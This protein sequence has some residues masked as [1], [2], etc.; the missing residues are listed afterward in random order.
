MNAMLS[1]VRKL[2]ASTLTRKMM[3]AIV[4]ALAEHLRERVRHGRERVPGRPEVRDALEDSW[5]SGLREA[6]W[7]P[8]PAVNV[9]AAAVA[10][11][12]ALRPG[13]VILSGGNDA[14][15]TGPDAV[16]ER[17]ETESVLLSLAA[18][19][20]TPVLSVCPKGLHG[21]SI[22]LAHSLGGPVHSP[23]R[24]LCTSPSTEP[25]FINASIGCCPVTYGPF[26]G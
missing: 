11:F 6:G 3:A 26:S 23:P 7:V 8:F 5:A 1:A 2:L 21:R 14:P 12:E 13:L 20:R 16:P 22:G 24:P 17:D 9:A 4:F 18:R 25:L 10:Q 19:T 15:G